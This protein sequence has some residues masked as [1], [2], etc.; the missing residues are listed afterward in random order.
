MGNFQPV[1]SELIDI[2]IERFPVLVIVGGANG[3][4]AFACPPLAGEKWG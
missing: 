2:L 3:G 4:H 1:Q